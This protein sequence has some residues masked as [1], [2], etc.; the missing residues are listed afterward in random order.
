V[1]EMVM[2]IGNHLNGGSDRGQVRAVLSEYTQHTR[3]GG[4]PPTL[5]PAYP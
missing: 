2:A 5:R 1:L 3:T 4:F